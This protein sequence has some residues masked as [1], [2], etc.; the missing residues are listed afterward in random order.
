MS[1]PQ[2]KTEVIRVDR[3]HPEEALLRPAGLALRQGELVAFPTETVYGLGASAM[4]PQAVA[5]IF[6][7]KGRPPDN[8]LI[9]HSADIA[10]LEP[11]VQTLSPLARK[12]L[13]AFAPGPLTLVLP[14]SARV[15]AVVTA[16]LDTVAV[17][18]PDHPV[19][20]RLLDLAGIGVAAPSA[21]RSGRPS[22][23]LAWHVL[24]DL[25]GRIPYLID[26]G[27]CRY[28]L[29]ST[30]VDLSG[31]RPVILRPG[32]VTAEAISRVAGIETKLAETGRRDD[33]ES[34]ERDGQPRAPG[35]KY[36]H[37]APNAR[38]V[39]AE[40]SG[41]NDALCHMAALMRTLLSRQA[42]VGVYACKPDDQPTG[43]C[44]RAADRTCQRCQSR[45]SGPTGLLQPVVWTCARSGHG[46][47]RLV[48]RVAYV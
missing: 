20:H 12:L 43:Y 39:I 24:Q 28:G 34:Q 30:V 25:D 16:G 11:L 23:T 36:R 27:P 35:M 33:G 18:I 41:G 2:Y 32:S 46:R 5:R 22:P 9:V 3:Q 44:L 29:E 8:P 10:G 45:R 13:L 19:A 21:N 48:R 7:V 38:V 31:D 4:N 1:D 15:P 6:S 42:R 37:Y 40:E 14:R 26:G 47:P 17:R